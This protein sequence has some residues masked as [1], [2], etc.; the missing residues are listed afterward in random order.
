MVLNN[1]S[2]TAMNLE[3]EQAEPAKLSMSGIELPDIFDEK[4]S[5]PLQVD[6][7][8][9][10][11][12]K[13]LSIT[14]KVTDAQHG[15]KLTAILPAL[16]VNIGNR[17]YMHNSGSKI[18][19]NVWSVVIGPSSTTRKTTVINL[20]K[21]TMS[22]FEEGIYQKDIG[23]Y[24]KE[25]LLLTNT[26]LSKMLN[27]LSIQPCRLFIHN[28][29]SGFLSEMNKQYNAGM[30]QTITDLYDGTS[31]S[32][33]SREHKEK[34]KDPS[35]SIMSASTEGW[36]LS[37]LGN[38]SE[39]L[40]GFTQ[41]FLYCVIK[42]VDIDEL[43]TDYKEGYEQTNELNQYEE[44][45]LTMRQI[46]GSH[47]LRLSTQAIEYRNQAFKAKLKY[48]Q[49]LKNEALLSYFTRIYDGYFFKFCMLF[50][51][52]EQ[53]QAV[54]EFI[55]HD[56]VS[57]FFVHYKVTQETAQQAFYLCDYY[58]ENTIPLL[59]ALSDQNKLGDEKKFANLLRERFNGVATHS[60]IM[61]YGHFNAKDMKTIVDT[62][63][64]MNIIEMENTN[65]G[66]GK[67]AYRY[68]LNPKYLI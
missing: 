24:E 35:L 1:Y 64:E 40:S 26:T 23:D 33:F 43:N 14:D 2:N 12:Q 21:E 36:F 5:V 47:N 41:R 67:K 54:K 28:E 53:W 60:Q 38:K 19:P 13:Y 18:F 15:A 55:E 44:M 56:A 65:N 37:L 6:L 39:Q 68:K 66:K 52:Y 25:T 57:E 49:S 4:E 50:S 29:I 62:L 16:A 46:K 61:T 45:Y 10:F 17:V 31:R 3:Y 7:L 8:P 48:A 30:K 20:A 34:I 27:L 11:L 32:Y 59:K 63:L 22:A 9:E 51:L 42:N 58:F